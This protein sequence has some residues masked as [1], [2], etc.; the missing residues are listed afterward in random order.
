MIH[1]LT[2][3]TNTKQEVR[4]MDF[5][6][7]ND[8]GREIASVTVSAGS[9]GGRKS[10]PLARPLAVPQGA[11]GPFSLCRACLFRMSIPALE[12]LV[13]GFVLELEETGC[14]RAYTYSDLGGLLGRCEHSVKQAVASLRSA[15]LVMTAR[16]GRTGVVAFSCG[17]FVSWAA[18]MIGYVAPAGMQARSGS[19]SENVESVSSTAETVSRTAPRRTQPR[20][21]RKLRTEA[22]AAKK[23]GPAA[24][25]EEQLREAL[26]QE[27]AMFR[28]ADGSLYPGVWLD[29]DGHPHFD[30]SSGHPFPPC[31]QAADTEDVDP[32]GEIAA[33]LA[34][35]GRAAGDSYDSDDFSFG[36][37]TSDTDIGSGVA[38]NPDI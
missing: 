18:D 23:E 31:L 17:P 9:G 3:A 32:S 25:L 14:E 2:F 5:R 38:I 20:R 15:G 4:K 30:A 19:V 29:R 16:T 11:L 8:M 1:Y 34:A 22:P 35:A 13:L 37:D 24:S 21:G 26:E 10:I 36:S 7:L 33:T 27:V 28:Q 12:K 6:V